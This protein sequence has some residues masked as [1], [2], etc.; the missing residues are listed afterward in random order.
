[1]KLV[2]HGLAAGLGYMLGRPEG[3]QRLAKWGQ[4]AADLTRRPE[5]VQLRERGKGLAAEQAQA[6]KQKV[7]TRSKNGD[8]TSGPADGDATAAV[9]RTGPAAGGSRWGLRNSSWRSRLRRSRDVHFPPSEGIT[10]PPA[11]GGTTVV[12]DSDAALRGRAA[13]ASPEGSPPPPGRS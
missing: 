3:R 7:L 1:M 5:V 11:L 12:D 6:V 10:P 4:Q 8:D 2:S 9:D 13:I